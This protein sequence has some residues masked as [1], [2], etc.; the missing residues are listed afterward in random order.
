MEKKLIGLLLGLLVNISTS[1]AVN[2]PRKILEDERICQTT[3]S[4]SLLLPDS[5]SLPPLPEVLP[6]ASVTLGDVEHEPVWTETFPMWKGPYGASWDSISAPY[7]QEIQWLRQAKFGFWVHFGPQSVG[8]CGDWYARRL[9]ERGS[10]AYQSHLK[11]YGHPSVVG[12]KDVLRNWNPRFLNPDKYVDMFHEAGARFLFVMGVHHDNYDL[13][14]SRYQPWNSVNIGP[15]RDILGEWVAA[16]RKHKM[17]Y[18]ITFHHEYSWWWWQ[19]AFRSDSRGEYAN[20]PYDGHLVYESSE[21]KWWES[22]PLQWLY[23]INLREYNMMDK[24]RYCLEKGIFVRHKEYAHWYTYQWALRILDAIEK[25][26][27]DFIYTD[28]NA[29]QPFCGLRSGS[30]VKSNAVQRVIASY[31]NR[32]LKCH[33]MMDVFSIVKFHPPGRKGVVTTFEN[34]FPKGIKRDQMWIGE[35]PVGDWFYSSDTEYSSTSVIRY[36]LECVSRDG[37]CAV[38]IPIRPDGS[39]DKE[40]V[41]M[42]KEIGRWMSVNGEG[43]YGS[44]AWSVWGESSDEKILTLPRGKKLGK[45]QEQVSFT[46]HDFRFTQ[47]QNGAIYAYCLKVPESG[48]EILI[49]S[50]VGY[51]IKDVSLLG[52]NEAVEWK[53]TDIGL[54]IICPQRME[55][56][57]MVVTFKIEIEK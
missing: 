55:H 30:G 8:M 16:I 4:D 54:S 35:V 9:Y 11:N 46:T 39:L 17:H 43:I 28:G 15:H 1:Q 57:K 38:N 27:P 10:Q 18:G 45:E 47:G 24:F 34:S 40:C 25:Y 26:D 53:Q 20:I 48:E 14:N 3:S 13:W 37:N 29:T 36:L 5:I 31:Y 33:G 51:K 52:C 49:R 6:V 2:N 50:L 21:G 7:P 23:G 41:D 19:T 12:Y 42:L 44:S 56:L 22:Y 32:A